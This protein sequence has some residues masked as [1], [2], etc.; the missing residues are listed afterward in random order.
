MYLIYKNNYLIR[1]L[2]SKMLK[3][4]SSNNMYVLGAEQSEVKTA[5]E[6]LEL[7]CRG[8]GRRKFSKTDLNRESSRSHTVFTIRVV[9]APVSPSRSEIE[10]VKYFRFNKNVFYLK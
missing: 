9:Q 3:E 10:Q 2:S 5:N 6:A 4:D 7:F 8:Q 1:N